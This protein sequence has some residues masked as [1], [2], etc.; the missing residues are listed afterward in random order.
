MK[1]RSIRKLKC[2]SAPARF[3][4][5]KGGGSIEAPGFNCLPHEYG[6]N[7]VSTRRKAVAP[8]KLHHQLR[9]RWTLIRAGF[10]SPKGG[11]SI[12]GTAT[13]MQ[14]PRKAP[15]EVSISRKAVAPLKVRVTRY[16]YEDYGPLLPSFHSPKGGG[17]IEGWRIPVYIGYMNTCVAVSIAEGRWLH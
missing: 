15:G 12:E 11:G 1:A 13:L 3:H 9:R 4:S 10:H 14:R 16:G 2:P 5:P 17:S 6:A 7:H 8:L